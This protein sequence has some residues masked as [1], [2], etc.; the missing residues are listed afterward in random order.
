MNE[1]NI[2]DCTK[3]RASA[4]NAAYFYSEQD[5]VG[6]EGVPGSPRAVHNGVNIS[7]IKDI[8]MLSNS[9]VHMRLEMVDYKMPRCRDPRFRTKV[10]L[11]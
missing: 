10:E 6:R 11:M 2:G 9:Q 5:I 4:Y 3:L 1:I 8:S 7:C